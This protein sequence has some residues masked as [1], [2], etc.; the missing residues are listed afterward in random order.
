MNGNEIE[1]PPN[2]KRP[3]QQKL[4]ETSKFSQY[5]VRCL[6]DNYQ[7]F[8]GKKCVSPP[9]KVNLK[10]A[11]RTRSNIPQSESG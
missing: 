11:Y 1:K 5:F 6:I 3:S 10:S 9:Y 8:H 4:A 7:F 2:Q